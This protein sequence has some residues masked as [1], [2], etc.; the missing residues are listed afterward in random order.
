MSMLFS[1]TQTLA[2]SEKEEK[3]S[4]TSIKSRKVFSLLKSE[5]LILANYEYPPRKIFVVCPIHP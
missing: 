1:N 3:N 4:S 5:F 2:C